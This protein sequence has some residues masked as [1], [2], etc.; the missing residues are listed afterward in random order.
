MAHLRACLPDLFRGRGPCPFMCRVSPCCRSPRGCAR[1]CRRAIVCLVGVACAPCLGVCAFFV[2]VRPRPVARG[3]LREEWYCG[4]PCSGCC[5][6]VFLGRGRAGLGCAWRCRSG[7][8]RECCSFGG[9]GCGDARS[10]L[11]AC[12]PPVGGVWARPLVGTRPFAYPRCHSMDAMSACGAR[13]VTCFVLVACFALWFSH[14][15]LLRPPCLRSFL[16]CWS[17]LHVSNTC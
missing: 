1:E 17:L 8:A 7:T 13:P 14:R 2:P 12:T 3:L 9:G 11:T 10:P 5:T 16:T 6:R 15:V 4:L